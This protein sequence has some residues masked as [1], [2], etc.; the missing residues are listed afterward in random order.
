MKVLVVGDEVDS[1]ELLKRVLEECGAHVLLIQDVISAF[2]EVIP[3][4]HCK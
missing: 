1:Q 3:K 4:P 2:D